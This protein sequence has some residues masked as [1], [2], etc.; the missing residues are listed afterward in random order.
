[1]P[2]FG[3]ELRNKWDKTRSAISSVLSVLSLCLW[4]YL[5]GVGAQMLFS[6]RKST[7]LPAVALHAPAWTLSLWYATTTQVLHMK[8]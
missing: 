8:K 5:G 4:L 2:K 3:T 6:L 7:S 1:M